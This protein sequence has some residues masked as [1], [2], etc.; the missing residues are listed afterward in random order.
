MNYNNLCFRCFCEKPIREKPCPKCGYKQGPAANNCLPAGTLLNER[1]LVGEPLGIGGFGITYKCLDTEVGGVCAVKEYFPASCAIRQSS[2]T[3][4]VED[5][6][7]ERYNRI[8]K[9]FVEEAALVKTLRHRNVITIYDNFF[10]NNTAYYAMEYCDGIDLRRYTNNFSRRIGYDEGMNILSQTM[11]GLEYIHSKGILHRDIAPD[12]I[13]VTKNNTVKILDFGAARNEMDQYNKEFSVIVKVGY[14]PIEQYGGRGKQGP[15]TDIYALGATFYHLFTS[16]IPMEST[17]RVSEDNLV[18]LSKLRPDLPDNLKYAIEKAMHL[19]TR[20][21]ISSIAEMKIIL[22]LSH[23]SERPISGTPVVTSVSKSSSTIPARKDVAI[24]PVVKPQIKP[25][26]EDEPSFFS[27]LV[28]MFK[29]SRNKK[30]IENSNKLPKR[31][32]NYNVQ[33]GSH[34][35]SSNRGKSR[36]VIV[37]TKGMRVAA[38]V[39]D[40]IIWALVYFGITF[41]VV[42][43]GLLYSGNYGFGIEPVYVVPLIFFPI[44]FTAI[45][46]IS[47]LVKG[48]TLG[49]ALLKMYV[50]SV[51]SEKVPVGAVVVRNLV[52]LLTIFNLVFADEN[53]LLHDKITDTAVL[54]KNEV[55]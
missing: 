54:I 17:Q 19:T 40:L 7:I 25:M 35:S 20:G 38:Y 48:T 8:M 53:Q 2:K 24:R 1:Y 22:G 18:P 29:S 34:K 39:V 11:D 33:Q 26:V 36:R 23:I 43:K 47:E 50:R 12:N 51:I 45:N 31:S 52:K 4:T 28:D 41:S 32:V 14:A 3:V 30:K 15:Y 10:E 9:R 37:A 46:I 16:R 42:G 44:V 6:N 49:K 5:Q 21:R 13:F 55:N 27:L